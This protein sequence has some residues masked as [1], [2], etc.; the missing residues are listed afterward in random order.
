MSED[1]TKVEEKPAPATRVRKEGAAKA[2]PAAKL[3]G[4]GTGRRKAA[5]ARVV[6]APGSGKFV[7]NRKPL[8]EHFPRGTHQFVA[9]QALALVERR[10]RYDIR[11]TVNGG[12]GTGQAGAVRL[13][14]ARA[15]ILLEPELRAA[16]KK[17]GFLTRDAREV[18][19]KKYGQAKARKRFQFSKR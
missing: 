18:E 10:D 12:G 17:A 16:L 6:L 8:E 2:K 13:G 19:R 1:V 4:N 14:T 5:V 3:R 11:V 7:V 9:T 15:L